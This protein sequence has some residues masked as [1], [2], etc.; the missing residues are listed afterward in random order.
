MS[1]LK[2]EVAENNKNASTLADTYGLTTSRVK[3]LPNLR[4]LAYP[5]RWTL[6]PSEVQGCTGRHYER[7]RIEQ[8]RTLNTC[9]RNTDIHVSMWQT[10]SSNAK[11]AMVTTAKSLL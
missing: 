4:A 8:S 10:A 1:K 5:R 6:P 11:S 7:V 2:G 9:Q 3:V